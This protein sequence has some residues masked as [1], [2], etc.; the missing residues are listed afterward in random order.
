MQK[1]IQIDTQLFQWINSYQNS[2]F[3]EI[4]IILSDRN[5]LAAVIFCYFIYKFY[6]R[7]RG[8]FLLIGT[9]L[10]TFLMTDAFC[11]QV[12]KPTIKRYRPCYTLKNVNLPDGGCGG[13]FSLP[14]N[15]AANSAAILTTLFLF[16]RKRKYLVLLLLAIPIGYSR[17]YLG[18]HY[19]VDIFAGYVIGFTM[20]ILVFALGNRFGLKLNHWRTV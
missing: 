14:S 11:F 5:I 20:A 9:V 13:Y 4:M 12:L 10:T 19:P 15:H 8:A 3:D 17:I 1:L 6:K 18:V 2:F 16:H 7:G